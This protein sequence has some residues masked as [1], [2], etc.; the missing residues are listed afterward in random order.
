[1]RHGAKRLLSSLTALMMVSSPVVMLAFAADGERDSYSAAAPGKTVLPPDGASKEVNVTVTPPADSTF[2]Q[3]SGDPSA[4]QEDAGDGIDDGAAFTYRYVG[5]EGTDYDSARKPLGAGK[6]QVIATL[7]SE[8]HRGEGVSD[9]F[10]ISKTIGSVKRTVTVPTTGGKRTISMRELN[11]Y[12]GMMKGAKLK[13]LS[14]GLGDNVIEKVEAGADGASIN[15]ETK[16]APDGKSQTFTLVFDSDNYKNLT[17]IV[18]VAVSVDADNLEITSLAVKEP[19]TFPYGTPLKD[20]IDLE[21]CAAVLDGKSI[22]GKFSLL[23]PERLYNVGED[24]DIVLQFT[25]GGKKYTK[26]LPGGFTIEPADLV[27]IGYDE[28]FFKDGYYILIFANSPY[29]ASEGKLKDLPPARKDSFKVDYFGEEIT[30]NAK[31]R[32]DDTNPA[33][34]PQGQK[35]HYAEDIFWYDWYSFT[36]DLSV[37]GPM[38]KNM[39][40]DKIK[41]KAYVRVIPVEVTLSLEGGGAGTVSAA[42]IAALTGEGWMGGLH[43]PTQADAAC[44]PVEEVQYIDA[45]DK[46]TGASDQYAITGWQMDGEELTLEALKEK[47]A[48]ARNG[49]VKV[50]LTPVY[51]RIPAWATITNSPVFELTITL[52]E[53]AEP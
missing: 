36:A 9:T 35:P 53:N 2:G 25:G 20:I 50:T 5:V 4:V 32:V 45:R 12:S 48:G 26:T 23:E 27:P 6:Y 31:W 3:F 42:E 24:T 11:L 16:P 10:T 22:S 34:E 49:S 46:F 40:I 52:G 39:A 1:M 19:G 17:V 28:Q 21:K 8:T 7:D 43:L 18:T 29:N 47:A 13:R 41:P 33:F 44:K 51:L 38:V 30:L 15:L 37:T 14:K